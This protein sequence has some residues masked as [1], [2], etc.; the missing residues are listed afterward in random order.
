MAAAL[1]CFGCKTEDT[2]GN[3]Y[4]GPD[5]AYLVSAVTSETINFYSSTYQAAEITR[6]FTIK[7]VGNIY[8]DRD[9]E[10]KVEITT[11]DG[12]AVPAELFSMSPSTFIIP[13]GES[14]LMVTLTFYNNKEFCLANKNA[15]YAMTF[16]VVQNDDFMVWPITESGVKHTFYYTITISGSYN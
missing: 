9:R 6:N 2:P 15:R 14:E 4:D 11:E 16:T 1:F 13:K 8:N 5:Y 3:I 10:V 7:T 12:E